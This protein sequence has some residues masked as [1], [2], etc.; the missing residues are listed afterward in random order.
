MYPQSQQLPG[1]IVSQLEHGVAAAYIRQNLVGA[2]WPPYI[3][4]DSL[5]Q[6]LAHR[7]HILPFPL[8]DYPYPIPPQSAPMASPKTTAP[9]GPQHTATSTPTAYDEPAPYYVFSAIYD[10]LTA[11]RR[12]ISTVIL[13]DVIGFAVAIAYYQ[14][15]VSRLPAIGDPLHDIHSAAAIALLTIASLFIGNFIFC[16]VANAIDDGWQA[17]HRPRRP[18]GNI[19]LDSLQVIFKV[20]G[21][22]L[23]LVASL[24]LPFVIG[25]IVLTLV[26]IVAGSVGFNTLAP[27]VL[28]VVFGWLAYCLQRFPLVA[29]VALLESKTPARH[30]LRRSAQLLRH[31]TGYFVIKGVLLIG[32]I[33]LLGAITTNIHSLGEL[34]SSANYPAYGLFVSLTTIV[35]GTMTVFYH[36]RLTTTN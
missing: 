33:G 5:N 3:I 25:A 36:Q 23:L 20:I 22:E 2:G 16:M 17:S 11:I 12:N 15:F 4:D 7:V 9:T 31:S 28:F 32:F 34:L 8:E 29:Y 1:Y 27:I 18:I 30:S 24:V 19:I 21:S 6:T 35:I 14:A 10:A 26:E 13:A